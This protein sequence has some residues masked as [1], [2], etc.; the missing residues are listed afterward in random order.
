MAGQPEDEA[1]SLAFHVGDTMI[2]GIGKLLELMLRASD[3]YKTARYGAPQTPAQQKRGVVSSAAHAAADGFR[4]AAERRLDGYGAVGFVKNAALGG[5]VEFIDAADIFETDGKGELTKR[6]AEQMSALRKA[7]VDNGIGVSIERGV[8]GKGMLRIG[9]SA[10]NVNLLTDGL[11]RAGFELEKMG[12]VDAKDFPRAAGADNAIARGGDGSYPE[13]FSYAGFEFEKDPEKATTWVAADRKD[14]RKKISVTENPDGSSSWSIT[15]NGA[16]LASGTVSPLTDADRDPRVRCYK[17]GAP[18]FELDEDGNKIPVYKTGADGNLV[19]DD[20]GNPVQ[21]REKIYCSP[22]DPEVIGREVRAGI[23]D[24]SIGRPGQP[25]ENAIFDAAA[26]LDQL[27]IPPE[28]R[29]ETQA[30]VAEYLA[31][32]APSG[33]DRAA[34]KLM[35][36]EP[37]EGKKVEE[38]RLS[39]TIVADGKVRAAFRPSRSASPVENAER[40]ASA[41][42]RS[43]AR[44]AARRRDVAPK[45]HGGR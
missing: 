43:G 16:A 31:K 10:K 27:S 45:T 5:D 12:I 18:A 21:A 40:A 6:G 24:A 3:A 36:V 44:P 8:P 7:L 37:V 9:V 26:K 32:K 33:A 15:R 20:A 25:L 14:P 19:L 23:D 30:Q 29:E 38:G 4:A 11:L 13:A 35:P 42:M 22:D 28:A 41:A 34:P 17:A 1:I 2:T 39:G